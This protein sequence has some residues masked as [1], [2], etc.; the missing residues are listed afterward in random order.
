MWLEQRSF[1]PLEY[2]S[3]QEAIEAKNQ[4]AKRLRKKGYRVRSFILK[5]QLRKYS[6]FGCPDG[7]VRDVFMIDISD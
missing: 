4:E 7:K 1:D 5:N 2:G 6:S 3:R